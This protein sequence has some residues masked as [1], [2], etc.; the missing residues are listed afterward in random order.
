MRKYELRHLFLVVITKC[1]CKCHR[2]AVLKLFSG[3]YMYMS[4]E[5]RLL[6]AARTALLR[7]HFPQREVMGRPHPTRARTHTLSLSHTER[8]RETPERRGSG[9]GDRDPSTIFDPLREFEARAQTLKE[10]EGES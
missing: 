3:I 6:D 9:G 4:Q 1:K 10:R 5:R 2:S 7:G 8:E